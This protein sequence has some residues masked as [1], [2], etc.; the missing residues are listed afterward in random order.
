LSNFNVTR[1]PFQFV[2]SPI[3]QACIECSIFIYQISKFIRKVYD[4]KERNKILKSVDADIDE[5]NAEEIGENS[6]HS[7]EMIDQ[8]CEDFN[9]RAEENV[10]SKSM[11]ISS[12]PRGEK[13]FT[14]KCHVCDA[15]EF[16]R[17]SQLSNHTRKEHDCPPKVKCCCDKILS[18]QKVLAR[19][20]S[21]HF[22]SDTDLKCSTCDKVF[23]TDRGL[24]NHFETCHGSGKKL[25]ICSRKYIQI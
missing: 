8:I 21:K 24:E 11:R 17:M 16:E 7:E 18:T 15:P 20:R 4:F 22:P 13:Y 19:H 10:L 23:R 25:F 1:I 5:I 2:A 9:V 6:Q 14:F 12:F 3:N